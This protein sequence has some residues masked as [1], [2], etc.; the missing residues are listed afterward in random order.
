M[1]LEYW[2]TQ[3]QEKAIPWNPWE[4]VGAAI[5]FVKN[6]TL[7]CIVD[8]YSKFPT[9]ETAVSLTADNL[10][11]AAKFVII[12]F[13]LSKKIISDAGTNFTSE[14]FWQFCRQ[15]NIEQA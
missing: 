1:H 6:K 8:Y 12:E 9:V 14:M 4:V 2:K 10:V 5:F 11:K 3:Q 15:M 13:E 7:L